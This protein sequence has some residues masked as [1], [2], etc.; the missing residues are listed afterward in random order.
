MDPLSC[1]LKLLYNAAP[2]KYLKYVNI[3][4]LSCHLKLLYNVMMF[5]YVKYIN[6]HKKLLKLVA[7]CCFYLLKNCLIIYVSY[8]R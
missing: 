6:I 8:L 1:R 3:N 7:P 4:P 2:F 5:K